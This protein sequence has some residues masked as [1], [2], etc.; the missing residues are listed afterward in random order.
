ML[1]K[2]GMITRRISNTRFMDFNKL[3]ASI[4]SGTKRIITVIDFL[5]SIFLHLP[6]VES[7]GYFNSFENSNGPLV[8]VHERLNCCLAFIAFIFLLSTRS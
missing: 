3:V 7:R 6:F 1:A 5:S 8:Y 2:T 4:K